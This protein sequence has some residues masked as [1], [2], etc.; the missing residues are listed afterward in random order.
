MRSH[1]LGEAVSGGLRL[2]QGLPVG[3]FIQAQICHEAHQLRIRIAVLKSTLTG[4][5]E[6]V[7]QPGVVGLV[8]AAA[9]SWPFSTQ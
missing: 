8:H 6:Q 2:S 7:T 3:E 1:A 9:S 4:V 5:I